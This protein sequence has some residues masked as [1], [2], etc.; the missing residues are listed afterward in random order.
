M[1]PPPRRGGSARFRRSG[2]EPRRRGGCGGFLGRRRRRVDGRGEPGLRPY[3]VRTL[4]GPDQAQLVAARRV[5]HRLRPRG[6]TAGTRGRVGGV[7]GVSRLFTRRGRG[8]QLVRAPRLAPVVR[9]QA[10]DTQDRAPALAVHARGA[11]RGV[12]GSPARRS[13][14]RRGDQRG[15]DVGDDPGRRRRRRHRAREGAPVGPAAWYGEPGGGVGIARRREAARGPRGP[16]QARKVLRAV[17]LPPPRGKDAKPPGPGDAPRPA[18]RDCPADQE[19]SRRSE[20]GGVPGGVDRAPEP[21]RRGRRRRDAARGW[22]HMVGPSR[23]GRAVRRGRA[24]AAGPP[25]GDAARGLQGGQDAGLRRGAL[26]PLTGAHDSRVPL[27]QVPVR[28]RQIGRGFRR[29]RS[30]GARRARREGRRR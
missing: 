22:R 4:L 18:D 17:H 1:L 25:P 5:G 29:R 24:H 14:N 26:V 27:L 3:A 23:K 20:R 28:E 7:R 8:D 21:G 16:G 2:D 10:W 11:A 30:Q 13:Q 15:G 12:Q 6:A 19:A 9:A